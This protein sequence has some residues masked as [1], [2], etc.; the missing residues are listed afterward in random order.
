MQNGM[1]TAN[2]ETRHAL[3][4]N[5]MPTADNEARQCV[6]PSHDFRPDDPESVPTP[7]L[8]I[9]AK[10]DPWGSDW[11]GVGSWFPDFY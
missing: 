9:L 3:C 4:A 11:G 5:A 1:R 7:P 10:D 6:R 8:R 2:N